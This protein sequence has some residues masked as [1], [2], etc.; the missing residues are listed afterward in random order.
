VARERRG[1]GKKRESNF[2]PSL[3]SLSAREREN[4]KRRET[5]KEEKGQQD[6]QSRIDVMG[7]SVQLW[8]VKERVLGKKGNRIFSH[9]RKTK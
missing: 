8:H 2:L 1:F 6:L 9:Q 3:V 4:N 7:S 5:K